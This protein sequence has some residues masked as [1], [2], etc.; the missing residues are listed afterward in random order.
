MRVLLPIIPMLTLLGCGNPGDI[1]DAEYKTYKELGS[2]KILYSCNYGKLAAD[3]KIVRECIK[4]EDNSKEGIEKELAC[5]KRAERE[6]KPM[7]EVGYAAGI[8]AG[9]TYNKLLAD[10]KKGCRGEFQVLDSKQ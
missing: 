5:A 1:S 10:A 7:I 2:P 3:P 9:V 4:N 6:A 8:G